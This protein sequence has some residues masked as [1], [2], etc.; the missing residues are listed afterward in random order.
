MTTA[1]NAAPIWHPSKNKIDHANVTALIN[2]INKKWVAKLSNYNDLHQFS[3]NEM[4]KFWVSFW[5]FSGVI[6]ETR[7]D[8][9][10]ANKDKIW[11]IFFRR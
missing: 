3:I 2:L 4:E 11:A 7:G 6:A 9:V 8:V 10:L 5:D 1:N